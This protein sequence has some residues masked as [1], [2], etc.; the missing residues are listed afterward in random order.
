MMYHVELTIIDQEKNAE[1]RPAHLKYISDLYEAGKVFRGG[2]FL[3]KKGG[4]VIYECDSE[5]EAIRL[6]NEDPAVTSGA[7]TAEVRAWKPLE[8][9]I[10]DQ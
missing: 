9:P 8:F 7:R 5:E 4:L 1:S 6:A 10:T 3:D 2:P